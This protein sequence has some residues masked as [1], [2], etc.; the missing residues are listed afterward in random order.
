MEKR[1]FLK[2]LT[3]LGLS[4]P[5]TFDHLDALISSISHLS[6][7]TLAT[8]EDFWL[9]IR[10][11][12]RLKSDYIN[13]EN[14]FYCIMPKYIED[15]Y[16]EHVKEINFQGSYYMRTVQME[17]KKNSA[18]RLAKMAGCL[19]EELI[20]TRNTTESL[21][22][23]IQGQ[24]WEKGDEAI[25][26]VQDYGA[27]RN[28]FRLMERRF[29]IA[30]REVSIPNHPKNDEEIIKLYESVITRK[31][32]LLM[33][34]HMVN[35]TGQIMP[36]QKICDMAHRY[37]VRVMVDGAHAFGHIQFSIQ[38]LHCDYYGTSLHKWLTVPLGAGF[39]YI[40][41]EQ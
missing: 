26:A 40:K 1:A 21:N 31:T 24:K 33:I 22:L 20:I 8:H 37:G 3:G 34:C 16:I 27:M 17:N 19:P 30:V 10:T 11:D 35:I 2:G 7:N 5:L 32:R 25:M 23:V 13:L 4:T 6:D 28:Q 14:G 18:T 36:V 12:Y 9:K 39:L 15:H 38:D 41:K 29:G